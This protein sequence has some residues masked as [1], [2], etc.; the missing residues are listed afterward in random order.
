MGRYG[1]AIGWVP[2]GTGHMVWMNPTGQR[3]IR[4]PLE[5]WERQHAPRPQRPAK[6]RGLS[7]EDIERAMAEP[8]TYARNMAERIRR[9]HAI[10][11][12]R[13]RRDIEA[14]DA[15]RRATAHPG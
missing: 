12:A 7:A 13:E 4:V 15:A 1:D 8:S 11:E 5:V 6:S 10:E 14:E 9:E 2:D 3:G